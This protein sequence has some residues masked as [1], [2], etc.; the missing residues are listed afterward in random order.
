MTRKERREFLE[1]LETLIKTSNKSISCIFNS[2]RERGFTKDKFKYLAKRIHP[3][4]YKNRYPKAVDLFTRA[5]YLKSGESWGG[6]VQ[7]S[8]HENKLGIKNDNKYLSELLDLIRERPGEFEKRFKKLVKRC[9]EDELNTQ[10]I[11]MILEEDF[12]EPGELERLKEKL[13]EINFQHKEIFEFTINS[14]ILI[15]KNKEAKK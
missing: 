14:L 13:K 4:E 7:T 1:Q 15:N 11:L 8:F 12:K 9:D 2:L 3:W 5:C 6:R 10:K